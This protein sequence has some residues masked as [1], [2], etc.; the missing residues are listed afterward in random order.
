MW[1]NA[2]IL[3]GGGRSGGVEQDFVRRS[4]FD[5]GPW[6]F[7]THRPCTQQNNDDSEDRAHW[8]TSW[9]ISRHI[10][11]VLFKNEIIRHARDVVT[12]HPCQRLLP[13]LLAVARR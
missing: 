3:E 11:L 12:N 10:F 2:E 9:E 8:F 13:S 1:A 6:S 5:P 4:G 7:E